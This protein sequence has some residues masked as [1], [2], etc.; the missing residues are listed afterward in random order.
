[1]IRSHTLYPIE[2]QA[3]KYYYIVYNIQK[4]DYKKGIMKIILSLILTA[5]FSK[6]CYAELGKE[7]GLKIPRYVSLKSDEVNI[8]VGPSMN[9]PIT[10]KYVQKSYP[11]K[12]IEEYDNWRKIEDFNKTIGW[13]HKSLISGKRTGIVLPN[14]DDQIKIFNTKEGKVIGSIGKGNIIFINK[15][16]I[17]W[18]SISLKKQKGWIYKKNIWGVEDTEII[19]LSN[20]QIIIDLYWKSL[21]Y[22]EK[23]I[24]EY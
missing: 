9:Y 11:L 21:N 20:F 10:I 12:I 19:N 2:L 23:T 14:N 18:C 24:G 17:D 7:T 1:M 6:I 13:I 8:R 22:F 4:L 5:F 15:C 16:K 3:L